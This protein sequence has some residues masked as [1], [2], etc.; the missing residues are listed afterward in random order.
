MLTKNVHFADCASG[1]RFSDSSRLVINWKNDNDRDML[2]LELWQFFYKG[3]ARN[4]EIGN[5]PVWALGKISRLGQVKDTKFGTNVSNEMLLN[6][7][8]CQD[9]SFYDFWVIK[10]KS[11]E[12]RGITSS[13]PWLELIFAGVNF[14]KWHFENI[15]VQTHSFWT[16][17]KH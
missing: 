12:G 6:D 7:A 5:T 8:K 11:N 17:C 15:N 3:L 13:P 14:K 1:I 16:L 2:V 4:W 9:C 10:G